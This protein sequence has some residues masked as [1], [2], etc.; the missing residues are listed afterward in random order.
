MKRI[1]ILFVL[2]LV[3]ILVGCNDGSNRDGQNGDVMVD[4]VINGQPSQPNEEPDEEV[5]EEPDEEVNE[6]PEEDDTTPAPFIWGQS[7]WGE[8]TW[9]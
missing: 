9:E 8:G 5:N 3:L 6:E 1:S 4:P 2:V 7:K